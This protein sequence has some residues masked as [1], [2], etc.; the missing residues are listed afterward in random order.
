MSDCVTYR[1]QP[2]RLLCPWNFLGKNTGVGCHALYRGIFPTQGL[3]PG[4]LNPCIAGRFFPT[5]PP[6][7][8][9]QSQGGSQIHLTTTACR[10]PYYIFLFQT[11]KYESNLIFSLNTLNKETGTL[12]YTHT[13]T[14]SF[15]SHIHF[16]FTYTLFF[17]ILF[18]LYFLISKW[19][20]CWIYFMITW[21]S[22]TYQ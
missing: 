12:S 11:L 7:K 18:L 13:H 16:F 19:C 1:L 15:F 20:L 14:T 5:E 21:N 2:I 3:N 4:L 22:G 6:G 17:H 8:A 10:C 9:M